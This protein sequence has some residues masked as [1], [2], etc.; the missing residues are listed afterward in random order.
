MTPL[1]AFLVIGS[2][3]TYK[4]HWSFYMPPSKATI[5]SWHGFWQGVVTP[6]LFDAI[7]CI[8]IM[9][10]L[11]SHNGRGGSLHACDSHLVF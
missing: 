1:I 7:S 6:I 11:I 2:A 9:F 4:S 10:V 8:G 5:N 3:L